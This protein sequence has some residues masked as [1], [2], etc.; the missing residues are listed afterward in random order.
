M[1]EISDKPLRD[2]LRLNFSY[3][4]LIMAIFSALVDSKLVDPGA[5]LMQAKSNGEE[6][7]S[8]NSIASSKNDFTVKHHHAPCGTIVTNATHI[9]VKNPN[10]PEPI[11]TKSICETVIE[12]ANPSV[13][14]ITVNFKQLEL[15]RPM[16]D[17]TCLQDRFALFTD[18]N[19]N[20]SPILC[21]NHTGKTI[22]I[23]FPVQTS[24]IA[25]ITTSDLD[26]DRSWAIEI[27]QEK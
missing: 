4:I 27:Q 26:H 22:T 15:Y 20:I 25:S 16:V 7:I 14:K 2:V 6:L 9:L 12:R 19:A 17:G 23:P 11:Y 8:E 1:F 18:L 21:G 10:H 5:S 24:L 3:K 13:N